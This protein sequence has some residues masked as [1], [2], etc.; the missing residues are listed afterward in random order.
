[1]F[2][3]QVISTALDVLAILLIGILTT[4]GITYVQ[5]KSASF[6]TYLEQ[7]PILSGRTFETQFAILSG[8]IVLLFFART[9]VLLIGTKR[10]L[11]FLGELSSEV[12]NNIVKKLF[13]MRVGFVTS[14]N[15]QD[16]LFAISSGIDNLILFFLGSWVLI[17]T[18]LIFLVVVTT[19]LLILDPLVG[20]IALSLFCVAGLIIQKRYGKIAARLSNESTSLS[21]AFNQ[22]ILEN[23]LLFRDLELRGSKNSAIKGIDEIRRKYLHI[24]ATLSFLPSQNKY[25]FEFV[26][27][28]AGAVVGLVQISNKSATEAI[29]S[30][31]V[32]L[33]ASS[34]ILPS[35]IRA[36]NYALII[37]QSRASAHPTTS[38]LNAFAHEEVVT[39]KHRSEGSE[40]AI[41]GNLKFS[42]QV[43]LKNVSFQ[44]ESSNTSVLDDITLKINC[45]DFVAIVGDSGAGKSTLVNLIL[46]FHRP[47]GGK[48]LVS[49]L[50][51]EVAVR[52]WPGKVSY[53]PQELFLMEGSLE[54]NI[55]LDFSSTNEGALDLKGLLRDTL[56]LQ[57]VESMKD[58]TESIVSEHRNRLSGGQKQR[59]AI[60]RALY[61]RPELL[62]LDEATS[63]LDAVTEDLISSAIYKKTESRTLIVIAH[64]LSTVKKADLVVFLNKGKIE[65]SG[66]FDYVRKKVPK[67]DEQ[68]R[69]L[70]L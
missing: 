35:V 28:F 68:A 22:R 1:M 41:D 2:S 30:L 7:S 46:G 62:V 39:E 32:F 58:G 59:L 9:C 69:L 36:Q 55:K 17:A 8:A 42:P 25:L 52:N 45:G 5:G 12:S 49:G 24:R 48:V 20:F 53:V 64:R 51:P 37:K 4:T 29:G 33:A 21:L 54:Q 14:R 50:P 16:T 57:D 66:T 3:V 44:Y 13:A 61:T 31:V 10:I 11:R 67:F 63:S 23:L 34:R 15:P 47:T 26:M 70:N 60:A 65:A 56:L 40:I 18:E 38:L 27:I 6:P 43:E 19:S